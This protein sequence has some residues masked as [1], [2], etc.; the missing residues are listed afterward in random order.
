MTLRFTSFEKFV[1]GG[2]TLHLNAAGTFTGGVGR[3]S[4]HGSDGVDDITVGGT[5]G[6]VYAGGGDDVIHSSGLEYVYGEANNDHLYAGNLVSGHL[7]GGM[8]PGGAAPWF[9]DGNDYL[10]GGAQVDF[11]D[12]GTG[13]NELHGGGGYD[14]FFSNGYGENYFYGEADG[15]YVRYGFAARGGYPEDPDLATIRDM[16]AYFEVRTTSDRGQS[17]HVDHLYD[18]DKVVFN[19]RTYMLTPGM[20]TDTG[21][22]M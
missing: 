1:F 6:F 9:N 4:I 22:F 17:Y 11:L 20:F 3:N 5:G 12:G 16:G 10:F 15:G 18:I 2:M 19:D 21:L 14:E 7:S 8:K 13:T